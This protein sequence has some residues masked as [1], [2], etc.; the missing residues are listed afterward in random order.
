MI[1]IVDYGVGNIRAIEN[2]YRKLNVQTKRIK[3]PEDLDTVTKIILPGVGAFD[4]AMSRLNESGLR[5][6]LDHKV[7]ELKVQVLGICVGMQIMADFSDEGDL[8]GLGWIP[9]IVRRFNINKLNNVPKIPHM[10]WNEISLVD[11]LL[12]NSVDP[13]T[14]FYFL[15]SY[16]FDAKYKESVIARAFYNDEFDCAVN[17]E[18]IF[19]VQFHPE[20]SHKNGILLFKNFWDMK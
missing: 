3:R 20:K 16:Y 19:A 9:G 11:N 14:G 8:S 7:I 13:N 17:V 10:G 15:H 4:H 2:I 6:A 5:K 12:L 18:N 1:G